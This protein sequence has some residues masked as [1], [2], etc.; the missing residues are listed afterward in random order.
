MDTN[1]TSLNRRGRV[2]ALSFALAGFLVLGGF[3]AVGWKK[4]RNLEQQIELSYQ[5]GFIE[6]VTEVQAL[7]TTLRK[8]QY[9]VSPMMVAQL[10][11]DIRREASAAQTVMGQLPFGSGTLEDTSV[12]LT[13]VADYAAALSR[14][15][16]AGQA[17][18]EAERAALQTLSAAARSVAAELS[19]LQE[20]V[21]EQRL[22]ISSLARSGMNGDSYEGVDDQGVGYLAFEDS[23]RDME[24]NF[25][26]LP[27]LIYDGPFS[28]HLDQRSAA[29]LENRPEVSVETALE[30]A[31]GILELQP[32]QLTFCRETEGKIPAYCFTGHVNGGEI[33]VDM[34]KQ[35]GLPLG[36][37]NTR[38]QS[39]A[40]L[41]VEESI[42]KAEAFLR[43]C[44]FD[45]MQSSYW[46]DTGSALVVNFA[47]AQDGALIYPDLIKVG[48][49]RDYGEVVQ[50][51]TRGYLM[52]HIANRSVPATAIDD[53]TARL[54]LTPNLTLQ[55][56]RLCVIPS[57][58]EHERLCHELTCLAQDGTHV[59]VYV[60]AQTGAEEKILILVEDENGTLA[61]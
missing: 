50:F 24:S 42:Q 46:M 8:A 57:P 5:R 40:A 3:A 35:G 1:R 52:N 13:R 10:A 17:P 60:S 59:L 9:A 26:G 55:S 43:R 53:G 15:A 14:K 33:T 38:D 18:D 34:T 30:T 47:Y 19:E 16:A 29:A 28:A 39:G 20:I 45:G 21:T 23:F 54:S 11:G 12:F 51:E 48:I 4:T 22:D 49:A 27:I 31:L 61:V 6:L 7:D 56:S 41:S 25:D 36:M 58:G 2:R 37:V 32:G 44:G